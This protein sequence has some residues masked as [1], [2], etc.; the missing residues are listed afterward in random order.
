[1]T[2]YSG[3]LKYPDTV[4]NLVPTKLVNLVLRSGCTCSTCS[5]TWYP[6]TK[7]STVHSSG[8]NLG[9]LPGLCCKK[10]V[11]GLSKRFQQSNKSQLVVYDCR[12]RFAEKLL[13]FAGWAVQRPLQAIH[14]Q[15]VWRHQVGSIICKSVFW[16][17]ISTSKYS[18]GNE[19]GIMGGVLLTWHSLRLCSS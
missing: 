12:K 6:D 5:Y 14:I 13:I 17:L 2:C 3:T 15:N 8:T 16:V 7:F 9:T 19:N 11:C 1:M 18:Y 4:L 10:V